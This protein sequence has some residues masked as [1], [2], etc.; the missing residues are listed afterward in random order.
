MIECY[1]DM[2]ETCLLQALI[3]KEDQQYELEFFNEEISL[4][5]KKYQYIDQMIFD[6]TT[7]KIDLLSNANS[8][9]LFDKLLI[10]LLK[11]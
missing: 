2:L 8:N 10:N 4:I 11:R 1:L 7:A 5:A 6:I 9:L 3:K